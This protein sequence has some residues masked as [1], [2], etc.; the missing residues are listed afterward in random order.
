MSS[1][2]RLFDQVFGAQQY[3]DDFGWS[4]SWNAEIDKWLN[5]YRKCDPQH[6]NRQLNRLKRD[7]Q[8]DELLA[9]AK[10]VFYYSKK[11][12]FKITEIEPKGKGSKMLD[13]AFDDKKGNHWVGEVK[14]P[15]WRGEIWKDD[16]ISD[17]VKRQRMLQPQ[18]ISGEAR[19]FSFDDAL[20]DPI[21]KSIPKFEIGKNNL[22]VIV[23]NMFISIFAGPFIES[24]VK[25]LLKQHD[26]HGVI[27]AVAILGI[28][29][30]VGSTGF[31]YSFG[32][33]T[34]DY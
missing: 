11:L 25:D 19:S 29:L 15:N 31:D 9:E 4:P 10:A 26:A 21:I 16:S 6:F 20:E 8:R 7:K 17:D 27:S 23:P 2:S 28:S 3:A 14:S 5:E 30:P 24:R 13:F 1:G 12:N 32:L 22:L 18:H 34:R 33:I